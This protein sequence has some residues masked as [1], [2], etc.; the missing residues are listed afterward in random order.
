MKKIATH[1]G[2]DVFS[3]GSD[4]DR[5]VGQGSQVQVSAQ[6][7]QTI[8]DSLGGS[9][10][11]RQT[12]RDACEYVYQ[13]DVQQQNCIA[14]AISM[15]NFFPVDRRAGMA[16]AIQMN[17][18]R[19]NT[20]VMPQIICCPTD[21]PLMTPNI[22]GKCSMFTGFANIVVG[23]DTCMF[24]QMRCD[25]QGVNL[26]D[27]YLPMV[28]ESL[29]LGANYIA[30]NGDDEA[31]VVGLR[32]NTYIPTEIVAAPTGTNIALELRRVVSM[33]QSRRNQIMDVSGGAMR[34][35]YTLFLASNIVL[36]MAN[37]W[38]TLGAQQFTLL[39]MLTGDCAFC[40]ADPTLPTFRII[41]MD[42]LNSA[43]FDG[44]DLGYLFSGGAGGS[45]LGDVARWHKPYSLIDLGTQRFGLREQHYFAARVG[46]VEFFDL[47]NVTR[48]IIPNVCSTTDGRISV[49]TI[50]P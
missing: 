19:A 33:I 21:I 6:T 38:V 28:V 45:F 27:S 43:W 26:D 3:Y 11:N 32:N 47:C 13:S 49:E 35:T 9:V 44:S 14:P 23:F 41:S 42:Q 2:I 4:L 18:Q 1:Q 40:A 50:M 5:I 46:S 10:G 37:T 20:P 30:L 36:S 17:M 22:G 29:N 16:S 34:Q 8:R 39:S 48:L 24:D 31:N 25:T 12:N 7:A 15:A